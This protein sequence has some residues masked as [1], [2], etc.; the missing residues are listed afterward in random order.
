MKTPKSPPTL[1]LSPEGTAALFIGVLNNPANILLS[2]NEV[3]RLRH[4]LDRWLSWDASAQ[5]KPRGYM[6]SAKA[7]YRENASSGDGA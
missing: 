6:L 5:G 1:Y 7:H 4:Q 3:E 2:R